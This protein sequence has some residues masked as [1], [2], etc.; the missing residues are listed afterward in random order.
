MNNGKLTK[1]QRGKRASET[2]DSEDNCSAL[3]EHGHHEQGK[4]SPDFFTGSCLVPDSHGH[5]GGGRTKLLVTIV[6]YCSLPRLC[7]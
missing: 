3:H 6:S 7:R 5:N 4:S 2:T 1:L